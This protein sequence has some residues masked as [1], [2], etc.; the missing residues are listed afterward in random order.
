M[1][2]HKD[3]TKQ[4]LHCSWYLEHKKSKWEQ[5]LLGN[6]LSSHTDAPDTMKILQGFVSK[7]KKNEQA[8]SPVQ[9]KKKKFKGVILKLSDQHIRLF[10]NGSAAEP[11]L[12]R[13]WLRLGKALDKAL[14]TSA[15]ACGYENEKCRTQ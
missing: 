8:K 15:A 13:A 6:S 9:I 1:L 7:R 2:L 12:S 14:V 4:Q 5:K 3:G 11:G 10:S